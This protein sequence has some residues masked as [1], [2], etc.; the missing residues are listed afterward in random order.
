MFFINL[1]ALN[2]ILQYNSSVCIRMDVNE[3]ASFGFP[4]L[5]SSQRKKLYMLDRKNILVFVVRC[6]PSNFIL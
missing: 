5:I 3:K 4:S 1:K 6:S 2:C